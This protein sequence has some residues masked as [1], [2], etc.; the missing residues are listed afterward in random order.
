VATQ[1]PKRKLAALVSADVKGYSRLMQDN[2]E[3]TV[4]TLNEYR[5]LVSGVIEKHHGRVVDSPGDNLLAEFVSVV[6]AVQSAVEVQEELKLRNDELPQ[7]R[8]MEYRIGINV[9]DVIGEEGRIY[10]DGVNIAARIESLAEGGG[11]CISGTV[12]DQVKNKLG[13]EYEFLGEQTVKNIAEPVRV[14]RVAIA[15][16]SDLTGDENPLLPKGFSTRPAI[17]ALPFDN[18]SRDPDQEYFA[19]GLTEDLITRL[20]GWRM[21]PVIARNSTFVYKGQAVDVKQASQELQA[22]YLI[23]GSVRRA[24]D[25]IRVTAQLIDATTGHHV[26]AE[27]YDRDLEDIFR[28]QDEITEAIVASMYPELQHFET[29]QAGHGTPQNVDAW[30]RFHRGCWHFYQLTKEDNAKA[31]TF[32]QE[33]TVLDPRFAPAFAGLARAHQWDITNQWSESPSHSLSES[34][35]AAQRAVA[36]DPEDPLGQISLAL[37]YSQTGDRERAISAA[38]LAV[39]LNPSHADAHANLGFHLT[40]AGSV[41]EALKSIETALRLSP[42]DPEIWLRLFISALAHFAAGRYKE[43]IRCAHESLQRRPDWSFSHAALVASYAQLGQVEQAEAAL[44]ELLRIDPGFS[45]AAFRMFQP[46]PDLL[47]RFVEGLQL[48]G[49]DE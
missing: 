47:T 21:F 35:E 1:N 29:K 13:L 22:R 41:D 28:L 16:N 43:A 49:L 9:G 45:T 25:R 46:D 36:L 6:E 26:W 40:L 48:A 3:A 37:A 33:A 38:Q 34:L 42:R 19:D 5:Q 12:Y 24:G 20:S 8:R 39:R 32:F 2:E 30:E 18:L 11:I 31:R 23:E 4:A 14:Y 10:G 44:R 17:A 7:D 15:S 27:R